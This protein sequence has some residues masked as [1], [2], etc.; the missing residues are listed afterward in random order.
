MFRHN[1]KY[2]L[3]IL[4]RT[5]AMM[6]WLLLFPLALST[7]FYMA[8]SNLEDNAVF[9]AVDVAVIENETLSN[10]VIYKEAL[11]GLN[12][13]GDKLLNIKYRSKDKALDL[14][15]KKKVYAAIEFDKKAKIH[16]KTNG[17]EQ[18]IVKTIIDQIYEVEESFNIILANKLKKGI[19]PT[20]EVI[21][22]IAKDLSAKENWLVD[23]SKKQAHPIILSYYTVLA[24]TASYG[25]TLGLFVISV[26]NANKSKE[27]ARMEIM[28]LHK[29]K[30][31]GS[32]FLAS[33]MVLAGI[34]VIAYSYLSF[35]LKIDFGDVSV[36]KVLFLLFSGGLAG[37]ST[38]MMIGSVVRKNID[39]QI[40]LTI[41]ITM[42]F[43]VLAGMMSFVIKRIVDVAFP[44]INRINPVNLI[45]EGFYAL[46]YFDNMERYYSN[47]INLFIIILVTMTISYFSI[48]R[49]RYD[50]I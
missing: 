44:L 10:S 26:F 16:V 3:K 27:G 11:K 23:I 37:L 29:L 8:F 14:L 4:I 2:V 31:L 22:G 7:L 28:P 43:S 50:S 5:K 24:M 9:K 46:Y 32:A 48:R 47:I 39:F 15:E 41:S 18:T 45:S 36:M 25:A 20:N 12:K 30:L 35:V 33:F 34:L 49:Q 6:F 13:G 38:G 40:G 21:E 42:F 1:F 19:I 17:Y